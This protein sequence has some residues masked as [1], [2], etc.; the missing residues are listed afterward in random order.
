MKSGPS[1]PV[2]MRNEECLSQD[3]MDLKER[4]EAVYSSNS[5]QNHHSVKPINPVSGNYIKLNA[6]DLTS[7]HAGI[8]Y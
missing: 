3:L 7:N 8:L 5:I 4:Q 6:A 2:S 1:L